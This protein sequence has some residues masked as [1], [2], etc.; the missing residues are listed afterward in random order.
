MPAPPPAPAPPAR[1]EVPIT[2]TTS[3]GDVLDWIVWK[4]YGHQDP[5]AVEYVLE[6]NDGVC[7]LGAL[8]PQGVEIVLP[9]L[10]PKPKKAPEF[11]RFWG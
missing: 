5:G 8:L 10:P 6:A 11:V 2:Y 4:H 9:A 1:P 7:E 3:A